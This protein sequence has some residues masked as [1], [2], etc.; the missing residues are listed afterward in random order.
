MADH[1]FLPGRLFFLREQWD[2]KG[3]NDLKDSYGQEWVSNCLFLFYAV[4]VI[5]YIWPRYASMSKL[6]SHCV[7]GIMTLIVPRVLVKS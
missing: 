4:Y 1:G 7:T 3:V 6:H 2:S 5:R